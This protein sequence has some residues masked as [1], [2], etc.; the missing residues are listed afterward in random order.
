MMNFLTTDEASDLYDRA[1]SVVRH[2][3]APYSA[4]HVGA[5]V[6][7]MDGNV[8]TGVNVENASYG[9]TICAERIAVGNTVSAGTRD[10]RAIAIYA[11]IISAPP[12]GACRQFI[13]EFGKEI[14][15]IFRYDDELIQLTAEELLPYTFSG[16]MLLP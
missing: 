6:L 2:A 5:A 16:S 13:L 4:F 11:E 7:T 12:C 3:H 9:L 14:I 10:I 15:V 1:R 8:F